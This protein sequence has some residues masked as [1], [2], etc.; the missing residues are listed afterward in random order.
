MRFKLQVMRLVLGK[1]LARVLRGLVLFLTASDRM[2]IKDVELAFSKFGLISYSVQ[3][4][5]ETLF[6][7]E[8]LTTMV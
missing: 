4:S 5:L 8:L 7:F 1:L 2:L 6:T 3:M